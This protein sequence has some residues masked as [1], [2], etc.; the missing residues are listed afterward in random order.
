MCGGHECSSSRIRVVDGWRVV[1]MSSTETEGVKDCRQLW[2]TEEEE[3][4][5]RSGLI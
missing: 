1:G 2:A 3:A 5:Q 4:T